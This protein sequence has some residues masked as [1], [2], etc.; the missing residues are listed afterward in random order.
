MCANDV[1]LDVAAP[2]TCPSGAQRSGEYA[3]LP[4]DCRIRPLN[5]IRALPAPQASASLH[6]RNDPN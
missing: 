1:F 3:W 4:L 5:L 2:C 6:V